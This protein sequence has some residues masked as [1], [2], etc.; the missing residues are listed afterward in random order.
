MLLCT[1]CNDTVTSGGL[2]KQFFSPAGVEW[3]NIYSEVV[4]GFMIRHGCL[5]ICKL[6]AVLQPVLPLHKPRMLHKS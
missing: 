4:V 2:S 6:N 5:F 3:L 1:E